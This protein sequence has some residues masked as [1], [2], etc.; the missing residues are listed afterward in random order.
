MTYEQ[1]F[2]V[3]KMG[4]GS[5]IGVINQIVCVIASRLVISRAPDTM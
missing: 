5:A 4:D 3:F 1:A 2:G